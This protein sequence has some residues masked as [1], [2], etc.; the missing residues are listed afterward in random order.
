LLGG[1]NELGWVAFCMFLFA[2]LNRLLSGTGIDKLV[3][4]WAVF[5]VLALVWLV[6]LAYWTIFGCY[7]NK[8]VWLL[9][10]KRLPDTVVCLKIPDCCWAGLV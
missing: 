8:E 10:T 3:C 5:P 4:G 9:L 6:D 1:L 7:E 2:I